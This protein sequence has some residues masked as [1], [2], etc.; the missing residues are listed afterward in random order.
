MKK[1]I[2]ISAILAST[3]ALA[4]DNSTLSF[5]VYNAD[6]GS[7]HVNSTLVYG[8]TEAAVIDTGFTKADA[9][10]IAANV[11]DSGK[12]L[13]TI[14]ISQ[15]D[16]D[17]YFGAEVLAELFPD[18]QILTTKPVLDV[19]EKKKAGK[20]AFWGP[21]MGA[22]AP[23][24]PVIPNVITSDHFSIDG[25][26]IEIKGTQGVLAHRPYLWI[27]SEKAILGNV[28]IFGGL[29]A[30]TADTQSEVELSAWTQ[31]LN[32]MKALN[33]NIVIPGHMKDQ[34]QL[35][36]N[37]IQFTNTYLENF[38]EAKANQSESSGIIKTMTSAYP[39]AKLN[40]ALDIGAKVHTGEMKW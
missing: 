23:E 5:K 10:R 26:T 22:N 25:Q 20:L 19:I 2:L 39:D 29:H 27:P 16:P 4:A 34:A 40:I 18:A 24:T 11:L 35:Q 32:E 21:K 1:L 28:A 17:Y 38:I 3:S 9:Y 31:Q 15:A 13:K 14:F 6:A 37:S 8:D 33:P 7:F 12:N 30:W 36:T